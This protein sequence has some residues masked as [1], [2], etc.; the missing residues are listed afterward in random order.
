MFKIYSN[1]LF[2]N[3]DSDIVRCDSVAPCKQRCELMV[4]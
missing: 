1:C 3:F 2:K 4:K